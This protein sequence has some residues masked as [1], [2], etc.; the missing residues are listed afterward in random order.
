[1]EIRKNVRPKE[2]TNPKTW[3]H[4]M[5]PNLSMDIAK[6]KGEM[7]LRF[8]MEFIFFLDSSTDIR[9]FKQ[10]PRYFASGL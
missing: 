8:I 5:E 3:C 7:I 1:M 6:Y 9:T 2:L 4:E 10:V